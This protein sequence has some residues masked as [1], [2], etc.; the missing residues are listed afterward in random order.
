MQSGAV[1]TGEVSPHSGLQLPK[2]PETTGSSV[3]VS[4][5]KPAENR[6]GILVRCFESMGK[7]AR[8]SLPRNAGWRWV[9]T[10]LLE[11]ETRKIESD[12]LDFRPF[13]IKTLLWIPGSGRD[14]A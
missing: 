1:A 11:A 7:S 9:E 3:I 12:T 4:C 10:D 2:L 5:V 14:S 6:H 13:E 8:L